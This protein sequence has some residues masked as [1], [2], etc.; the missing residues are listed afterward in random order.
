MSPVRTY[1]GERGSGCTLW[2]SYCRMIKKTPQILLK[3]IILE[4][5]SNNIVK[6]ET[7]G[8]ILR[9]NLC[10]VTHILLCLMFE[11]LYLKHLAF[12]STHE[13]VCVANVAISGRTSNRF[14]I[15]LPIV[16]C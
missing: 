3:N 11:S 6:R 15:K 9:T 2:E 12:V 1:Q 8:V 14:Y 5:L 13:L 16:K 7:K 10:F 4:C